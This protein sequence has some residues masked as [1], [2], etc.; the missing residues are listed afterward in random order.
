MAGGT[1][2]RTETLEITRNVGIEEAIGSGLS[3]LFD[4]SPLTTCLVLVIICL[5]WFIR[6]LLIDAREERKL[7]R[8]A[9]NNATSVIS[10]LKEMIRGAIH[11][12]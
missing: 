11:S 7:S 9:L 4:I 6:F 1:I 2:E 12:K 8:E 5:I 10:E 3:S